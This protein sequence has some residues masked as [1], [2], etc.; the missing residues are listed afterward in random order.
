MH[1]LIELCFFKRPPPPPPIRAAH[2]HRLNIVTQATVLGHIAQ[3]TERDT[4]FA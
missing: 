2:L 3:A 4:L 1:Y